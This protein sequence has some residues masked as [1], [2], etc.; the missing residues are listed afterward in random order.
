MSAS[1]TV[2][3]DIILRTPR[4]HVA[5]RLPLRGLV[6]VLSL[7]ALLITIFALSMTIGSYDIDLAT[8]WATLL[9]QSQSTAIDNVVWQFRM[10]RT[11]AA[12]MVGAMMALSGAAMQNVTRNGLADPSLIGISQGA[13]LAMVFAI[14]VAPGIGSSVRP[15][16]A[17]CGAL[18]VAA[19]I[20]TLSFQRRG[21]SPIRFIL[22]GIGISAFISSI[23]SAM[24]TYGNIDQ[25]MSA[26]AWLAGSV[27]AATWSDVHILL[28]WC[29]VL[30]PM[31]LALSRIMSVLRMGETTAIGLGAPV[32]WARYGLITVGVG[33]AA[34]ATAIVGPIGFV[35]LI[36]PHAA[37][38]IARTGLGLHTILTALC[39]AVLVASADLIGRSLFAPIQIPAGLLTAVIGVPIFV[40]LLQR[41]AAQSHL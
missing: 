25:T 15:L 39:G 20:Q 5:L 6:A 7:C 9:G 2:Q 27:N 12:M 40:Y 4:Q 34:A 10:P 3:R 19:I 35:G 41:R 13:A 31:I 24:L 29:L 32:K 17:F 1:T 18:A 22:M 37:R 14:V 26:L 36:A 33:F 16:L 8:L 28:T 23:T 38:R 11:L 30:T 21:N